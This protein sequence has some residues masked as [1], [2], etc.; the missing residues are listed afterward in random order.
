MGLREDIQKRIEKKQQELTERETAFTIE[1]AASGAYIQAMQDMLKSLPRDTSDARSSDQVLRHGSAMAQ[2]R[3]AIQKAGKPLHITDILRALGRPVDKETR[4][5]IGGSISNYVRRGEIFTRTAPNTFGL[6]GMNYDA[7][8]EPPAD[9]GAVRS[10]RVNRL[11]E[12]EDE[13]PDVDEATEEA[14]TLVDDD[15]EVPF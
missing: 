12:I 9:F 10:P 4:L 7:P 15:D 13:P 2:A 3:N 5:S 11:E 14:P 6:A 8:Q 1:R